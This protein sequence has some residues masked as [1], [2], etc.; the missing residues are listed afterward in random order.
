[1]KK[2]LIF[3]LFFVTYPSFVFSQSF[4]LKVKLYI[5]NKNEYITEQQ[6]KNYE[7]YLLYSPENRA[8]FKDG[9]FIFDLSK[10]E[11]QAGQEIKIYF[12][13]KDYTLKNSENT[14]IIY[15][16]KRNNNNIDIELTEILSE[17]DIK[18]NAKEV[19]MHF[20]DLIKY[21]TSASLPPYE[22]KNA[23]EEAKRLFKSPDI[24]KIELYKYFICKSEDTCNNDCFILFDPTVTVY[25]D[26]LFDNAPIKW[27]F[28]I[29]KTEYDKETDKVI[30]YFRQKYQKQKSDIKTYEDF[31]IKTVEIYVAQD[32]V[33]DIKK[34]LG[35]IRVIIASLCQKTIERFIRTCWEI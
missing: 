21:I 17:N 15:K 20:F 27:D 1:M 11:F 29:L 35:V 26:N 32:E 7:F 6:L 19:V 31:T 10:K 2:Y 30:I 5:G 14:Y 8:Y 23:C 16:I 22:R 18:S 33:G 25:L 13:S 34:E 3:L 9:N 12:N 24:S 4:E 28:E